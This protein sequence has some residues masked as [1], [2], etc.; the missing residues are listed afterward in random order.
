MLSKMIYRAALVAALILMSACGSGD[1]DGRRLGEIIVG[2]WVSHPD[3]IVIEGDTEIRP[4]QISISTFVFY[5]DGSYNGM[6]RTGSFETVD[7]EGETG[8]EGD[9]KCDNSTLRLESAQQVIVA[10]VVSF[11]DNT[12]Q[13]RYVNQEYHVKVL[14]TIHKVSL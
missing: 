7:E 14:L 1:D 12:I 8:W 6:V 10:Q 9:Y 11:T 5:G 3:D 13:L 4:E 2:T